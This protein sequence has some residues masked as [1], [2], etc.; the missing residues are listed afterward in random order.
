MSGEREREREDEGSEA[1]TRG[2]ARAGL[3]EALLAI[4]CY[5]NSASFSANTD[6]IYAAYAAF[7]PTQLLANF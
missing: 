2:E 1:R 5:A 3:I 6:V 7:T 4:F